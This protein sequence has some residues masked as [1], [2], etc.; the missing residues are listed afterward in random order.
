M[1]RGKNDLKRF[2]IDIEGTGH[3]TWQGS[4]TDTASGE[5]V[6]FRSVLELLKEMEESLGPGKD[7]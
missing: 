3:S 4:L 7:I 2:L 5:K 1:A 6:S